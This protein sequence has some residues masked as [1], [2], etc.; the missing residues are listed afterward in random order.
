MQLLT[1]N[2]IISLAFT[3]TT[4]FIATSS[5]NLITTAILFTIVTDFITNQPFHLISHNV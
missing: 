2:I 4:P 3:T 1:F 5:T